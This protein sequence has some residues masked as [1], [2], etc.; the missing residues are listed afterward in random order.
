MGMLFFAYVVPV[1]CLALVAWAVV[2]GGLARGPRRWTLVAAILAACGV[3]ACLRTEGVTGGF[4]SQFAW[5]WAK[6]SEQKLLDR[7]GAEPA[8]PASA[9]ATAR[10]GEGLARLSGSSSRWHRQRRADQDRLE[11]L[12]S[13]RTVA[14]GGGTGLVVHGGEQWAAVH[15]RATGR[16]RSRSLLRGDHREAGVDAPRRGSLLGVEWR[17]R[18][19]RD[20]DGPRRARV[21]AGSDG[22]PERA[23]RRERRGGV[24]AQRGG[25]HR[26]QGSGWGFSGSPLVVGDVVVVA[27]SGRLAAYDR[28]TGA[29]RWRGPNGSESYASRS[30]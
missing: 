6:T 11:I 22:N 5:R 27:A 15:A 7:A 17:R 26:G 16:V 13:C 25:G 29:P 28:A 10:T 18:S 9:A 1:L 4:H 24:D 23:G 14:A 19:A 20:A 30:C 3:F 2:C 12:C 21:C 8:A